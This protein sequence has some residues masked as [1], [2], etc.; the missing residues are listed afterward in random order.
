MVLIALPRLIRA[1]LREA[2]AGALVVGVAS[3]P[4]AW[5]YEAALLLPFVWWTL[6]GG[7]VEPWRTRLVVAA[8]VLVPFWMISSVTQVSVVAFV[9]L[10]AYAIWLAGWL[11]GDSGPDA[12]TVKLAIRPA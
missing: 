2:A 10:A 9:V 11:R 3:S 8:Y 12:R 5:G 1:P 6:A 4:H 7:L